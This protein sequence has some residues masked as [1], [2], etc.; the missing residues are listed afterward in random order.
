MGNKEEYVQL[1]F[2]KYIQVAARELGEEALYSSTKHALGIVITTSL[3]FALGPVGLVVPVAEIVAFTAKVGVKT[4]MELARCGPSGT[5]Y[6]VIPHSGFLEV[7]RTR[8]SNK[9]RF[10]FQFPENLAIPVDNIFRSQQP[11]Y[12]GYPFRLPDAQ[13]I[14]A[15]EVYSF[16]GLFSNV[17]EECGISYGHSFNC[18]RN[19]DLTVGGIVAGQSFLTSDEVGALF[20]TGESICDECNS[21]L[22]NHAAGCSKNPIVQHFTPVEWTPTVYPPAPVCDECNSILPNHA[23]GCSKNPIIQHFTPFELKPPVYPLAP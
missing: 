20:L 6:D 14:D 10:P 17:C 7:N 22:P 4:A 5:A 16:S 1:F 8:T 23:T 13:L 12:V 11:A 15:R 9:E 18:S 2:K 3:K 19:R 21:I